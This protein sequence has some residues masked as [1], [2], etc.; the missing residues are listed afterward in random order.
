MNRNKIFETALHFVRI[1]RITCPDSTGKDVRMTAYT[2]KKNVNKMVVIVSLLSL[3][4]RY[5]I[6]DEVCELL[7][8]IADDREMKLAEL[9]VKGASTRRGGNFDEVES[10]EEEESDSDSDSD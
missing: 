10:E 3:F 4:T 2:A 5:E 9:V 8:K 6:S 1:G 7:R